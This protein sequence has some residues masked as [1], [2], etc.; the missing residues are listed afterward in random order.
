VR[1]RDWI[2]CGTVC[3]TGAEAD[4][5]ADAC[6]VAMLREDC[7]TRHERP[8]LDP[9]RAM[10]GTAGIQHAGRWGRGGR[11][12]EGGNRGEA[13]AAGCGRD[14]GWVRSRAGCG[15]DAGRGA[16]A[17]ERASSGGVDVYIRHIINIRDVVYVLICR[18]SAT[19]V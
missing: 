5:A 3:E 16:P 19:H 18:F 13:E 6:G 12:C 7:A 17:A 8:G 4:A 10:V 11:M 15:R 1:R 9:T 14:A 2:H